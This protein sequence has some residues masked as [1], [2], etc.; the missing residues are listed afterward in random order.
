MVD[1]SLR[2]RRYLISALHTQT[3][4][5]TTYAVSAALATPSVQLHYQL[6]FLVLGYA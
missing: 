2:Y 4:A 3:S 1:I 5:A 6:I